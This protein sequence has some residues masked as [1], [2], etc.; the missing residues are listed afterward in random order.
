[1]AQMAPRQRSACVLPA[2]L[3]P[4]LLLLQLVTA[5]RGRMRLYP[6]P[7][8]ARLPEKFFLE[9]PRSM[10]ETLSHNA[11]IGPATIGQGSK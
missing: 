4:L 5:Q 1:M 7:E 10:E 11:A 6:E 9:L 2:L 3:L 8:Y